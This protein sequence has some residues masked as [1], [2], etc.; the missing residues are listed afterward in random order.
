MIYGK[1]TL[2]TFI[3]MKKTVAV[4]FKINQLP[5]E[6][7]GVNTMLDD[8]DDLEWEWVRRVGD[9]FQTLPIFCTILRLCQRALLNK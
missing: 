9:V 1:S 8:T 6:A 4:A 3:D 2:L 7:E 5:Y